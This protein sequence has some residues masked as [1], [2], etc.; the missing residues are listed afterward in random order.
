[1]YSVVPIEMGWM[2]VNSGSIQKRAIKSA[3]YIMAGSLAGILTP[4]LFTPASAPKY[5]AGYALTFSL[6]ACSIILTIVMRICLDREN[7]NRDKNPKDVSHLS[8]EEQ[9]DL[10]DFHPD[11]RYIL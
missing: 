9:R 10:H 4:Y 11:F 1:M 6:Y 2:S 8:T 5:I 3:F 7:K